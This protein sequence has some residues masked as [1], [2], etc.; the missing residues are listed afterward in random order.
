VVFSLKTTMTGDLNPAVSQLKAASVPPDDPIFD[1]TVLDWMDPPKY[2]TNLPETTKESDIRAMAEQE[3]R[4][5]TTPA[6][7]HRYVS[8]GRYVVD[9]FTFDSIMADGTTDPRKMHCVIW[10]QF[11]YHMDHMIDIPEK[12]NAWVTRRSQPFLQSQS[13]SAL[14]LDTKKTTWTAFSRAQS[15]SN[16]WS[17]VASKSKNKQQKKASLP[18]SYAT[19]ASILGDR[20]LPSTIEEEHSKSNSNSTETRG[21]KR[22]A[23]NDD[24]SAVSDGKQSVLQQSLNVPVC[25]GT[26]RVT[27]RWKTKLDL[28]RISRQTQELKE[29]IYTLLNDI[30]DDDDGLLYKWQQ[31]GTEHHNSISKMTPTEVRQYISPSI[32]ILP[33]QSMIVIPL[34][35]GF[36]SSTPA[37][38]RNLA[39]T[40]SKLEQH[41]V[42]VSF[43]NCTST[44]G[45]LIIAGYI[46]LK[47]PMTTHRLRY[48]QSLRQLL[49]PT[50][51]AFD[52][53]LHKRTPT[54][55]QIPHL[56][57]QC[58]NKTVHPLSEALAKT[59]TG[60]GSALYIPR[61]ALSQMSD[62]EANDLFATHDAHV[63]S[64]RW[65]PL[66][67]LLS[68]LDKPRKEHNLDGSVT[69]RTTRE[70]ARTIKNRE[71]TALAQCDV[72]NGGTDQLSYLLFTPQHTEAANIAL[73]EYRKRLY[74][75][76]QREA[77][78]RDSVG[79]PPSINMSRSVIANLE[80][81]KRLSTSSQQSD[82]ATNASGSKHSTSSASTP[83]SEITDS[84]SAQSIRPPTPAES[85]RHLYS[86]RTHH[87]ESSEASDTS[88]DDDESTSATTVTATS[89]LSGG[90]M[91]TSSAKIRELDAIIQ[92]QK[93]TTAKKDAKSSERISSIERQLHRIND[94]DAKFA[95]VQT[96]FGARLNLFEARMVET[97]TA[98]MTSNMKQ[99]MEV[100]NSKLVEQV[101]PK[102][103]DDMTLSIT[104]VPAADR[105]SGVIS[106][107]S[108]FAKDYS[109]SSNSNS[110][111][112]SSNSSMTAESSALIQSPEHKRLRSGK[113]PLKESIRRHLDSVMKAV[114]TPPP[115]TPI[116]TQ[117]S[118]DSLDKAMKQ[119]D[120]I[121][122]SDF[123]STDDN[124]NPNEKP[125][126]ESQYTAGSQSSEETNK[127][128]SSSPGRGLPS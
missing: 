59:L 54:D 9:G 73:E 30:F 10:Y 48:L 55:Q 61:F 120:S 47:A 33:S 86:R 2:V 111:S 35:F 52:I 77:K 17:E 116:P 12:L 5:S 97:V 76:T 82:T 91:S 96:D 85:L 19:A 21:T 95:E 80:F 114:S 28:S 63:K 16:S 74:P 27:L 34:R 69:E 71:G 56:A 109:S 127:T 6:G 65:L 98:N 50:T 51:P 119:V 45:D 13:V 70:W 128:A 66:F 60:E 44:S 67:P 1:F 106:D 103:D 124:K 78:F 53:L 81:I 123:S 102:Q 122:K 11:T 72:V 105:T 108:S 23:S 110:N 121:L 7:W 41:A 36:T 31:D 3:Y 24:R 62:D 42:T 104:K 32:S 113:K 64:L 22:S 89:K 37:K 126:P 83:A 92:R 117:D 84:S 46:L 39:S 75:F 29:E 4:N 38:W 100:V 93:K 107:R 79:P 101:E 88:E 8:L 58:G 99:L 118:F 90:R 25:D 87:S 40:K 14:S 26:H 94:L 43:S 125:D 112:S 68:N 115:T 18:Q 15:L 20:S 49:S 57:V